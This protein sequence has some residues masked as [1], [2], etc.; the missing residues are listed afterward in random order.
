MS[1]YQ[2]G[3]ASN[4]EYV[5]ELLHRA[6]MHADQNAQVKVQ[7]RLRGVV[8]D[9]LQR[10]PNREALCRLDNEENYVDEAFERFWRLTIDQQIAFNTLATALH[11]L[12]VSLNGAILD[13]LRAS[14]RPTEDAIACPACTGSRIWKT[15]LPVPLSRSC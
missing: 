2:C 11:Y 14:S 7:Q 15:W 4:D 1:A 3:N 9:W 13:G 5:V 6:I 10:H 12:L 8:R